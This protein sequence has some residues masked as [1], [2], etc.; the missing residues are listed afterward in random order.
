MS[1]L[2]RDH[3]PARPST[4]PSP[5]IAFPHREVSPPARVRQL[6]TPARRNWA[7][8][9]MIALLALIVFTVVWA[10]TTVMLA[11]VMALAT[12]AAGVVLL[13]LMFGTAW[14]TQPRHR[15]PR[16]TRDR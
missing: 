8:P 5:R 6:V 15:I 14:I 3:D 10:Q 1:I 7:W 11:L 9:A 16:L 2:H 13:T 4:A 12:L